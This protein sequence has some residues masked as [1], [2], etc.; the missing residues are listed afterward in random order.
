MPTLFAITVTAF[1]ALLWAA[2]STARHIRKTKQRRSAEEDSPETSHQLDTRIKLSSE[3]ETPVPASNTPSPVQERLIPQQQA[4]KAVAP[5]P[6]PPPAPAGSDTP[7]GE[8]RFPLSSQRI[9][10][11]V[12]PEPA[13]NAPRPSPSAPQEPQTASA[14]PKT[15]FTDLAK[16]LQSATSAS[17][18]VPAAAPAASAP[19][20]SWVNAE[21]GKP[22]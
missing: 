12:Q 19:A 14:A 7:T 10:A 8:V 22:F 5:P 18:S 1:F 20:R 16:S 13:S 11:A 4:S 3:T 9:R 2:F 21:I 15:A 17:R 6:M